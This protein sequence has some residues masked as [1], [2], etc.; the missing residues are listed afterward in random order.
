MDNTQ[1]VALASDDAMQMQLQPIQ[2]D[3]LLLPEVCV[4]FNAM[5][6]HAANDGVNITIASSYRSIARQLLIWNAKWHGERP[7]YSRSN[8][9]LDT[10]SLSDDDK[11]HA[12]LI[13]SAL[14]GAS[15][16]H[17]GT[18]MD[19]Y[20]APAIAN[21]QQSLQLVAQEYQQGGPCA[22]LHQW[23]TQHAA[24]FGFYFPYLQ[25]VG[26]VAA[27][28]WHISYRTIAEQQIEHLTVAQLH[29]RIKSLAI[30]GKATIL[31]NIEQ[32]H[33]RYFLNLGD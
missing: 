19:V 33:H 24:Q 26:G 14:P 15:R 32:L 21:T 4:A 13:F 12:I 28:P 23:L 17:W 1:Q 22:E 30:A 20:D 16:H 5:Q 18:D 29:K 9:L 25:D 2:T 8:Q 27:E 3:H 10:A 7:L 11:L 6:K 31:A